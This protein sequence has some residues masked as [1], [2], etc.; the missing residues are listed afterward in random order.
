MIINTRLND[1]PLTLSFKTG[2]MTISLE[3]DAETIVFG[4]DGS[5]RLWTAML[6]GISYR[7]GLDGK[8]VAKWQTTPGQRERRWL[9]GQ[10]AHEIE[11]TAR[12]LPMQII[13]AAGDHQKSQ[14]SLTP[15]QI[16]WLNRASIAD[17][18]FYQA[19]IAAYHRVYKPIGILPPD[20]YMAVVLQAAEG[21]SFNTC[22][23]CNFYRDRPFRI[24]SVPELRQHCRDVKD[25]L[26]EGL[27][28]R[29]TIFLGD[30]NALVIP[31][32]R[33]I[34][35]M[36][37]IH[38]EFDVETLGGMYAFLDG[39]SGEKKSSA[40]YA[41]L[42]N[43]GMKRVYIGMESGS[44]ELLAYLRK[45]G[46]PSHAIQAVNNMKKAGLAVGIIILLG[47]GGRQYQTAHIEQTITAL[48]QMPLDL[49]DIIYFSELIDG[50]QL[51]Y[52]EEAFTGNLSPLSSEERLQQAL[53]IENR[54]IFSSFR[55]TPHISRYD[56]REFVY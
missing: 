8:I 34:S 50:D 43:L 55:G 28:L 49:D 22:T 48:N 35:L 32:P 52:T 53:E 42:L 21:C 38:Q 1:R 29:R 56:I 25:F 23:F 16:G 13:H 15:E 14:L 46:H 10:Q 5:G 2:S 54:L 36:E 11:E 40:D 24:K 27:S 45:P 39:F 33:L 47:A 51:D 12:Q 44:P 37:V 17:R 3:D 26:A 6:D 20:Q 41:T 19:D 4:Y 18:S 31:M 7:R 9:S 30:A